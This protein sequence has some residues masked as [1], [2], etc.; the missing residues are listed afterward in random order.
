MWV[1]IGDYSLTMEE[2][3]QLLEDEFQTDRH[4]N[5]A[6][7]LLADQI[8]HMHGFQDT[9]RG[10]TL[11]FDRGDPFVQVVNINNNHWITATTSHVLSDGWLR[12]F[13]SLLFATSTSTATKELLASIVCT[14]RESFSI[15]LENVTPQHDGILLMIEIH[16]ELDSRNGNDIT[17]T[18]IRLAIDM[19]KLKHWP[20]QKVNYRRFSRNCKG[21]VPERNV[22]S[23]NCYHSLAS[24]PLLL[25]AFQ[26]VVFFSADSSTCRLK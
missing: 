18:Q 10:Q 20:S 4:I 2:R 24:Y 19:H 23:G 21:G 25:N 5:A 12:V 7:V 13:D 1:N 26:R 8:P 11:S 22:R 3:S 15:K 14:K 9:T 17:A 16:N 6:Q